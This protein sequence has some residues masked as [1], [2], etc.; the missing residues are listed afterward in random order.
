[1]GLFATVLVDESIELPHFP[2]E[3]ER[4]RSWQSKQGLDVHDGPYRITEDGRLEKKQQLYRDK[5]D[6][7]KQS[8]AEK[9][10]FDSWE[11]YVQAYEESDELIPDVIDWDINDEEI[12]VSPPTVIPR[13]KTL[14]EEWWGDQSFH[15]TFEFHGSLNRDPISYEVF[16]D[17]SGETMERPDEYALDVYVEYE[18][19]FTKGELT[20]IVFMG[21]RGLDEADPIEHAVK[22]VEEWREWKEETGTDTVK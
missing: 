16:E 4:N 11:E 12:E 15:G 9:W 8:E 14:D 3:L 5:T 17:V 2:E 7:E 19:R 10:G 6:Q 13:E 22:Q 20:D 1:M 18:A 21:S